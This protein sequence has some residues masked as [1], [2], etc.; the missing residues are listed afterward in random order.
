VTLQD[1][2]LERMSAGACN[3]PASCSPRRLRDPLLARAAL[4]RLIPDVNGDGVAHADVVIEAIFE[5]VAAKHALFKALEP[6]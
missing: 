6:R 4:D 5:D 2:S 1:Q 3:G